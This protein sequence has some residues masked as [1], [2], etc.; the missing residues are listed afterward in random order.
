MVAGERSALANC[1]IR[2]GT[3]NLPLRTEQ[4]NAHSADFVDGPVSN[5]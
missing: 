1:A 2:G 3:G 4:F 5:F